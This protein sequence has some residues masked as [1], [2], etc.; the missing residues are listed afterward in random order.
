VSLQ[1]ELS[2]SGG[3]AN[4]QRV[5]AL[6]GNHL[7]VLDR[8]QV[9]IEREIPEEAVRNMAR[10]VRA[11]TRIRPR[12]VY[13]QGRYASDLV[14]LRVAI[15]EDRGKAEVEVIQDQN[16]PAPSQFWDLVRGLREV[17]KG[18]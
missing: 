5:I 14:T 12:R 9:R 3:V 6:E 11:L 10:R 2:E 16:D 1:I 17:I 13:G 7:R 18:G 8:G 4:L 15:S